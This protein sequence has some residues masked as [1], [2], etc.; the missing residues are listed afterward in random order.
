M[1]AISAPRDIGTSSAF[2]DIFIDDV[3]GLSKLSDVRTIIDVGAHAGFFSLASR[4]R[5]P[6]AIIHA[7]EPNP[8]TLPFLKSQA[9]TGRFDVFAE[10]VGCSDGM[11]SVDQG[12]DSVHA[13]THS[14]GDVPM[15]SI[16]RAI[17]RIGGTV[18]LLKLDC[19]GAEWEILTDTA[20]IRA[21]KYLRMEYHLNAIR[22]DTSE[23]ASLLSAFE[24]TMTSRDG[25]N[26]GRE[27]RDSRTVIPLEAT[28]F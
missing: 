10:A 12:L 2:V 23:L 24:C 5:F 25:P 18:D 22:R 15:I 13:T 11:V 16:R 4:M 7:Y 14:G 6:E 26:Y 28:L 3:Y 20:A 1:R 17:E 27:W 19:E 9:M 8:A 21:V